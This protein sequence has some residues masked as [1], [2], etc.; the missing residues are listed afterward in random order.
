M[1][2]QARSLTPRSTMSSEVLCR[3]HCQ[4]MDTVMQYLSALDTSMFMINAVVDAS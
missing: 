1:V 4:Q 2:Y 3:V